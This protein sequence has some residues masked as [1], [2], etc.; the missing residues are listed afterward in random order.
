[1]R[2]R[3]TGVMAGLFLVG[4]LALAGRKAAGDP[5]GGNPGLSWTPAP[6]KKAVDLTTT[7]EETGRCIEDRCYSGG[8]WID[9]WSFTY[10]SFRPH[11]LYPH[12]ICTGETFWWFDQ[13]VFFPSVLCAQLRYWANP[14]SPEEDYETSPI[15]V[16]GNPCNV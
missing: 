15:Y 1:M 4:V 9:A 3:R 12:G 6:G 14:N 2:Y 13:C 16:L 8:P 10:R 7:C 5:P 11:E